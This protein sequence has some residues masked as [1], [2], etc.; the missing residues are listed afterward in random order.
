[1]KQRNRNQWMWPP[2]DQWVGV[3]GLPVIA[4]I[5]IGSSL[6][7]NFFA[8]LTGLPWLCSYF[9]GLA[10]A[11]C[12]ASLIFYAKLP[13]YRMRRF[14]TFGSHALP[15]QRRPFYRWGYCCAILGILL[16]VCL[17]LSRQ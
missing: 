3:W 6:I 8:R 14:F 16:L 13:L 7:L 11:L 1:M 9:I 2:P 10:I 4:L 12:G 15:E 5:A 17:L